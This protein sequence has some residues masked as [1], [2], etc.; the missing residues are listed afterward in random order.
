[1]G[2]PV[3]LQKVR[4]AL[5]LAVVANSSALVLPG[6]ANPETP[7]SEITEDDGLTAVDQGDGFGALQVASPPVFGG[8][9]VSEVNRFTGRSQSYNVVFP[10]PPPTSKEEYRFSVS[11]G[12]NG[13]LS[14]QATCPTRGTSIGLGVLLGSQT[15]ADSNVNLP[16]A[17]AEI[18]RTT[19]D[20][21]YIQQGRLAAAALSKAHSIVLEKAI[22]HRALRA[23]AYTKTQIGGQLA[24]QKNLG[25]SRP[26]G[27]RQDR[28]LYEIQKEKLEQQIEI[29]QED[30]KRLEAIISSTGYQKG[31]LVA[32]S[33]PTS[34]LPEQDPADLVAIATSPAVEEIRSVQSPGLLT[35]LEVS[36][37]V[38][39][40]SSALE[41]EA[42]VSIVDGIFE[43]LEDS[44][45]VLLFTDL[46]M[47]APEESIPLV[48]IPHPTADTERASTPVQAQTAEAQNTSAVQLAFDGET[49]V[50]HHRQIALGPDPDVATTDDLSIS[51]D[52]T[53]Q[54]AILAP[55]SLKKTLS[56]SDSVDAE[57]QLLSSPAPDRP[58]SE[59][60][61]SM[62][63]AEFLETDVLAADLSPANAISLDGALDDHVS[64][65][66]EPSDAEKPSAASGLNE[67]RTADGSP[68]AVLEQAVE[69]DLDLP[70]LDDVPTEQFLPAPD[71]QAIAK[72]EP[73]ADVLVEP[74]STASAAA[75]SAIAAVG[76]VLDT[77]GPSAE[78][79][80]DSDV[81]PEQEALSDQIISILDETL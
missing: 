15:F 79:D 22:Y 74:S 67:S 53:S 20:L 47:V 55:D 63:L 58:V 9:N 31:L 45:D 62:E 30:A 66:V 40:A 12:A 28:S 32:H 21:V 57:A 77:L 14:Y 65:E 35:A 16:P 56:S 64:L 50:D 23:L 75:P 42:A 38:S 49:A 36:T 17:C 61:F 5:L 44:E 4:M 10:A 46:A 6:H 78:V 26:F 1:M 39:N 43:L 52:D 18:Q 80:M 29:L 27:K 19:A 37:T 81:T 68:L 8:V 25:V 2:S 48:D 60:S 24:R 3:Q 69:P 70:N 11:T 33:T 76:D 54:T 7:A 72:V 71:A 41:A 73:P 34:A 51:T 13:E 59:Q